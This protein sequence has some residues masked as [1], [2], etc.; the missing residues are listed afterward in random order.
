MT[1]SRLLP[2]P[3]HLLPSLL[4]LKYLSRRERIGIIRAMRQ[5]ATSRMLDDADGPTIGHW[6]REHGQTE[7]AIELF[8]TPVI[9]SALSETID[10]A[11]VPPVRKVFVD[12]FIASRRAYEMQV[13]R[14]PLGEFYG[15][16]LET[17]LAEHG[18]NLRLACPV[19][20]LSGDTAAI[21]SLEFALGSQKT[22]DAVILAVPWRRVSEL[23]SES[24]RAALPEFDWNRSTRIGP[25]HR[26][27]FV[28][29]SADHRFAAR[30]AA[31][32][33][34]PMG[35]QSRPQQLPSRSG[36]PAVAGIIIKL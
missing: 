3:L 25:D 33:N 14:V 4:R 35:V 30:R 8:W 11:A 31:G 6:L 10:R 21:R 24:L 20:Q 19:K 34:E 2:A 5:L 13:P 28:V 32:A 16:R 29:R 36:E 1:A 23:L 7:R 15:E 18:V 22:F 17:W 9:V 26:R 27:A 12:A